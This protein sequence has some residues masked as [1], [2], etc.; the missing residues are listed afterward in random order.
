VSSKADPSSKKWFHVDNH[1]AWQISPWTPFPWKSHTGGVE[2][3]PMSIFDDATELL[4]YV[5]KED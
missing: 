2:P 1:L 5:L 4:M 3:E